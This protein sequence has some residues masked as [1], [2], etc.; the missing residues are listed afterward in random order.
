MRPTHLL[1]TLL[2][3]HKTLWLQ[4]LHQEIKLHSD[5]KSNQGTVSKWVFCPVVLPGLIWWP[6]F[7]TEHWC[8]LGRCKNFID[9]KVFACLTPDL[10]DSVSPYVSTPPFPPCPIPNYFPQIAQYAVSVIDFP[11]SVVH[12]LWPDIKSCSHLA[13]VF[14]HVQVPPVLV[15]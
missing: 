9:L 8:P 1:S 7:L 14:R 6:E 13:F 12:V 15:L 2:F 11:N 5:S 4:P 3:I 10:G